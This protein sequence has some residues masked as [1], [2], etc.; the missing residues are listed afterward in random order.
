[1][2]MFENHQYLSKP[3]KENKKTNIKRKVRKKICILSISFI[4]IKPNLN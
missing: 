4:K 1:M 2:E 3:I